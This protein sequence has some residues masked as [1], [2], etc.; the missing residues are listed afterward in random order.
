MW[1][2]RFG[3]DLTQ[4]DRNCFPIK[5]AALCQSL[6]WIVNT[7]RPIMTFCLG[8]TNLTVNPR[9]YQTDSTEPPAP[10]SLYFWLSSTG[11]RSLGEEGAAALNFMSSCTSS[12]KLAHVLLWVLVCWFVDSTGRSTI[13]FNATVF[14]IKLSAS[15][16]TWFFCPY[17]QWIQ[18]FQALKFLIRNFVYQQTSASCLCMSDS[19]G[20]SLNSGNKKIQKR[21]KILDKSYR[22]SAWW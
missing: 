4:S 10:T 12:Q 5:R 3:P 13:L 20:K 14:S 19:V 11:F 2:G 8:P 17:K 15:I 22:T 16:Y 7:L 1:I 18:I 21:F 9:L 6:F